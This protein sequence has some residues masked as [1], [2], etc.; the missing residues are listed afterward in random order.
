MMV[1]MVAGN[2]RIEAFKAVRKTVVDQALQSPV[3]RRRRADTFAADLLDKFVGADR[4]ADAAKRL[5]DNFILIGCA[6]AL[7][8]LSDHSLRHLQIPPSGN[9]R[10]LVKSL[11]L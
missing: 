6:S 1:R 2:E 7:G 8:R 4:A 9:M 5:D 11:R 10:E 3:D